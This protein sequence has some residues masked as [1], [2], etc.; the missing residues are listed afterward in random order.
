MSKIVRRNL[1]TIK[2]EL[3]LDQVEREL[4]TAKIPEDSEGLDPEILRKLQPV[5]HRFKKRSDR[6]RSN[7]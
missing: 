7:D 3:D 5:G 4:S 2:S 1:K 6:G